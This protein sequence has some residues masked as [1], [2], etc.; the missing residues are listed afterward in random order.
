M[1][2]RSAPD[3][4]VQSFVNGE[5]LYVSVS[6]NPHNR[7]PFRVAR[8]L[9]YPRAAMAVLKIQRSMDGPVVFTISGHL[10][11][12]NV[13]ELCQLMDAEPRGAVLTLDLTDLIL[14][15]REAV[16]LLRDRERE[17]RVA[18]HN[19]PAYIRALIAAEEA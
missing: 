6:H 14:A 10:N 11:S 5:G 16:R 8:Q 7:R 19:C 18:L 4:I 15:D 3:V 1:G 9:H 13:G 12:E 2:G 17:A